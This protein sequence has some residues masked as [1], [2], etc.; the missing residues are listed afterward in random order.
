MKKIL[1]CACMTMVI[2]L[3]NNVAMATPEADD[4]IKMA[5]SG[6]DEEVLTAYIDASQI[7]FDLNAD[8][9]VTLKDLGV[10]AKVISE[11]LRHGHA[12]EPDSTSVA[13]A[14]EAIK[15][16]SGDNGQISS[17]A[18]VV[19]PPSDLNISFFYESL[20]PYGNWLTINGDWCWQPNA[21]VMSPDWAPYCSYGH[22]VDSDWGWC[23][24]SDYSWGWATFHY[25]RWFHH[26]TRG[27]CWIPDNEWG[28]AW[29]SWRRGD[30][31]CGWAP[32]P[33]RTRYV[34]REGF[35]FGAS[36]AGV[37]FE[38]NLTM[39]DYFFVPTSYFCDPHPWIH[40]V[41][42]VR[43]RE[44]YGRTLFVRNSYDFEHDHIFNRGIPVDEVSRASKRQILSIT[45]VNENLRPGEAIHRSMVRDNRL[46]I[47]KPMISRSAP[48]NPTVIRSILE[49]RAAA[50]PQRNNVV[51]KNLIQRQTNAAQQTMRD[52][53]SKANN[54][55]QERQN[56]EKA[57]KHEA[58]SEKQADLKARA[59]IQSMKAKNAQDHVVNIKR[60][61]PKVEQK[62]EVI[63]QSRVVPQP[64][65]ENRQQVNTQVRSQI[66]NEARVERQHEKT[67]EEMVRKSPPAQSRNQNAQPQ[68]RE[69]GQGSRK[70]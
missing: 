31:F 42:S 24:V 65:P 16:A 40:R 48:R 15:S 52:L 61:N 39:N 57:A 41:P 33:P 34:Y 3:T 1:L 54:A 38:F 29:V 6:V 20:Y 18:A 2:H 10:P 23:W 51:E 63:P 62:P 32:L 22:W 9:I 53:R 45:I 55:E 27:W 47:Y 8:D 13:E 60:W 35:Y 70:K 17:S 37:D 56:L 43:Q 26:R 66:Q 11:A 49:K 7:V 67:M 46:M 50:M 5:R 28:P 59:E 44:V 30:D 12:N 4:L 36:R 68:G 69:R 25:G 21:T 58:D 64:T 14:R 19:P